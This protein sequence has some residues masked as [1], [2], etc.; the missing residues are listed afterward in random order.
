MKESIK[1]CPDCA[2]QWKKAF[3]AELRQEVKD[4]HICAFCHLSIAGI[5]KDSSND[6]AALKKIKEIFG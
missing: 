6:C 3:E 5:C 4:N 1:T 2:F